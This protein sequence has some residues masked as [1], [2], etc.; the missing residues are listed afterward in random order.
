MKYIIVLFLSLIFI[1]CSTPQGP[2]K[3]KIPLNKLTL[4]LTFNNKIDKNEAQALSYQMIKQSEKLTKEYH[5]VSPPLYHNFLVNIGIKKRG[6][7][8]H[9]AYDM[10]EHAKKQN[11][12]NF[13]YYIGGANINDYW[14]EHNSLVITCKGCSFDEGILIDPWRNS[15]KLYFSKINNDHDYKWSKRGGK[16]N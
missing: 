2:T 8:W 14:Q 5:L 9:F 15:G 3:K 1:G 4:L 12:N 16:R 13:D 10:L 11:L 6:L 7:C